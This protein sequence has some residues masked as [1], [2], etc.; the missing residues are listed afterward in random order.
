[1]L[2]TIRIP[3]SLGMIGGSMICPA[4]HLVQGGLVFITGLGLTGGML[5]ES[6]R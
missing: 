6:A 1:M 5:G 2:G 3:I 4:V